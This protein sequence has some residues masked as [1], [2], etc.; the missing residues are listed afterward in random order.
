MRLS[1]KEMKD[2]IAKI[3]PKDIDYDVDLEGGDIAIITPTPDV[4][5]GGDGLVGQIA[6]KIKRR[7]V[8]RPHSSIMKDEAETEEFIRN[9]LSEKADVDM[10]YFDRCYCEVTVICGNPG[11]A[12]GRR[13]ANS[14]AIRDECGWLVKFERKPP[15]H[16]K[17]IHDIRGYRSAQWKE[18]KKLLK[19]FGLNI[20]RPKRPAVV[21]PIRGKGVKGGIAGIFG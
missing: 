9:L 7:I 6:K 5:G 18:R 14:K 11:E 19:D 8:L 20:Y 15:I 12:V 17:T 16:S 10:I 13:G 2:A 21:A 4:F 1:F 3:V